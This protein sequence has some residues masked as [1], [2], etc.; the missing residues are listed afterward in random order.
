MNNLIISPLLGAIILMIKFHFKKFRLRTNQEV[1]ELIKLEEVLVRALIVINNSIMQ[2]E[3]NLRRILRQ[4][5]L[6]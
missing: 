1:L 6:K 4:A 5:N 3:K 2:L